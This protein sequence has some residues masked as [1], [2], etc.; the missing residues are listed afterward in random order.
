MDHK[1]L[2]VFDL[3]TGEITPL[4]DDP[5]DYIYGGYSWSPDGKRLALVVRH[6]PLGLRD[7]LLVSA[8]GAKQGQTLRLTNDMGGFVSFSPD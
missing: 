5:F 7:L 8:N 3:V 2:R 1:M 4:F 6:Q